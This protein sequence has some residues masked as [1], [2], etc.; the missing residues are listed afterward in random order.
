VTRWDRDDIAAKL[1]AVTDRWQRVDSQQYTQLVRVLR[2]VDPV[3]LFE[4]IFTALTTDQRY[5]TQQMA[6]QLL[7]ELRPPVRRASPEALV[8][9][10]L[11]S[12]EL[13]V[14]QV[15]W[16]FERVFGRDEI[17]RALRT[18]GEDPTLTTRESDALGAL[19]SWLRLPRRR[20]DDRRSES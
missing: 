1:I 11:S 5:P 8:R 17:H 14:E 10:L 7:L 12:W 3:E 4:G 20:R 18:L 9:P 2:R 19:L 13:S 15:P 16:Y 6:G